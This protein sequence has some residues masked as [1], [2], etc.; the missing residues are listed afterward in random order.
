M[1]KPLTYIFL[2]TAHILIAQD[3]KTL[4]STIEDLSHLSAAGEKEFNRNRKAC[5]VIWEKMEN[6]VDYTDLTVVEKKAIDNVDETMVNY[7]DIEGQGCSWYC[8]GGPVTKAASSTLDSQGTIDY[9]ADNVH[10]LNYKNVWVE[11]V[12][13][14]G[15]GEYITYGFPQSSPRITEIIV[16]NGH[17]KSETAWRNNSRVKKL[18]MY[19]KGVPYAI[20]NLTDQRSAQ[21]FKVDTIGFL[22][23]DIDYIAAKKLPQWEMKFEILEVYP[24]EKYEDTVISEIYFDGIDVHCFAAG[25]MVTI[26]NSVQKPIELLEV[27]DQVLSYDI[28]TKTYI[29]AIIEEIANPIHSNLITLTFDDQSTI[30][31][32]DDHPLLTVNG[33]WVSYNPSKT[34]KDYAYDQIHQLVVGA[35]LKGKNKQR[36]VTSIKT[37]I[38]A[39][40]TYTIVSLDEGTSFIANGVVVGTEPLRN[41]SF[42]ETHKEIKALD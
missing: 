29:P 34:M 38:T 3:I 40:P 14:Y 33:D 11:G 39:Q 13:G 35:I 17:V 9:K 27:G 26:D 22:D 19:I 24:G 10:D 12:A 32:T 6:G 16:V 4:T 41:V 36:I 37:D 18:K 1:N 2:I 20:L 30:T 28:K 15:V 31:C 42:C 8:G 23:R 25:T 7:W 21:H 5:E